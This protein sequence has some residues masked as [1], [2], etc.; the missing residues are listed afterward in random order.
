MRTISI[1][2]TKRGFAA[3][4]ESGGGLTSGGSAIIITGK[5]GEARRPVYMPRGGHLA[6]GTHALITVHD[7][8]YYV[9]AGV[10][11]GSRSSASVWRIVS[12]SVKDID[13]EKWSASAEVELVNSFSKGE[14]DKPLEEKFAPAVEAAFRKA[15]SYHCR[16]AYYVD[17]SAKSEAAS[18]AAKEAGLGARLEDANVRLI[19][20]G[21]EVVELGEVSFKW[22]WQSQLYSEQAVANVERN[23]LQIEAELA[24]KERKRTAREAFQPKFEGFAPRAEA[25]GLAIE[26][27][28]DGVRFSGDYYGQQPYSEE[29][30][31]RFAANLDEREVKAAEAKA[32]ADAE[33]TYQQ[34]KIEAMELGL[35][36]D[37]RIW[38][39]RGG[40]TNAGDGWVIGPDGQDRGN[41]PC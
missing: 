41:T 26:F 24:E 13:G 19:A 10:S 8:F 35:P 1:D 40:R 7:G 25:I 12:T 6:C 9:R 36:T 27:S 14:W 23:I 28:D 15:S 38:S 5:N 11:C 33:A 31:A 29:G 39:R 37:I 3:M 2:T 16:S 20:L 17:T 22:G 32:K 4:W 30:L 18:K 21:R 34:R